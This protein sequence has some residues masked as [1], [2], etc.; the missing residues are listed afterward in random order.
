[1]TAVRAE[2]NPMIF[3][4]VILGVAEGSGAKSPRLLTSRQ[5]VRIVDHHTGVGPA[6]MEV[7]L[8]PQA[9]TAAHFQVMDTEAISPH[10]IVETPLIVEVWP[11]DNSELLTVT[12][13]NKEGVQY[14]SRRDAADHL[15]GT[16][17]RNRLDEDVQQPRVHGGA[18]ANERGA[19][20]VLGQSGAGKS[21][22]VAHLAHSGLELL[23]DEQLTIYD[24]HGLV[25][26]FTRPVAIK[27]GGAAFLPGGLHGS[28]LPEGDFVQ[29]LSATQLGTRHC[30]TAAPA[31]VVLPERSEKMAERTDGVDHEVLAPAEAVEA[32]IANSLDIANRPVAALEAFAWLATEVPVIR[33]RYASTRDCAQT[34]HALLSEPPPVDRLAWT[35]RE[36][37][38]TEDQPPAPNTGGWLE[39]SHAALWVEVGEEVVVYNRATRSVLV[40]NRAGAAV[41]RMLPN[42]IETLESSMPAGSATFV[43]SLIEHGLI[44]GPASVTDDSYNTS[45]T[46]GGQGAR[47]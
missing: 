5:E 10:P 9:A 45:Q 43:A 15:L 38:G 20:L 34:V 11:I 26:G 19:V 32:L 13:S 8:N 16:I 28:L 7:V 18:V 27:P 1:M 29:L 14:W 3:D 42:R 23:N 44:G 2:S 25:A 12:V 41:W 6:L 39:A 37:T 31:L 36:R 21:T 47:Q 30:L 4:G 35:V 40:L 24:E 17:T 46:L 22:L 33:L